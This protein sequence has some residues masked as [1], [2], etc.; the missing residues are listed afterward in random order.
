MPSYLTEISWCSQ[1]DCQAVCLFII[2]MSDTL[3]WT[4]EESHS[5]G[6]LD[7]H[8]ALLSFSVSLPYAAPTLTPRWL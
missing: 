1:C 2:T 7:S 8:A 5:R 4:K 3:N 6:P